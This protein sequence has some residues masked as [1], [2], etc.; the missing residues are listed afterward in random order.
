[1]IKRLFSIQS[2]SFSLLVEPLSL[3]L[4]VTLKIVFSKPRIST[5]RQEA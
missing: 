5:R 1:M 2:L 4:L 3:P